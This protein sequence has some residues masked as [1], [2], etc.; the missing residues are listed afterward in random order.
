MQSETAYFTP[1]AATWWTEHK[2]YVPS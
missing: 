2:T 1:G